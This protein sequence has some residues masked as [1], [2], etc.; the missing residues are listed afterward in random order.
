MGHLR[1]NSSFIGRRWNELQHELEISEDVL[2]REVSSEDRKVD[3]GR[4]RWGGL[5]E[6]GR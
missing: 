5:L 3:I 4:H 2:L 6:I 1:T